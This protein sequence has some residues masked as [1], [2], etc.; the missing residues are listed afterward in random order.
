MAKDSS[1]YYLYKRLSNIVVVNSP[2]LHAIMQEEE[3][4][5]QMAVKIVK[6]GKCSSTSAGKDKEIRLEEASKETQNISKVNIIYLV[7]VPSYCADKFYRPCQTVGY[8]RS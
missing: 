3:G 2:M 6:I 4:K 1:S 7:F 5:R 8:M